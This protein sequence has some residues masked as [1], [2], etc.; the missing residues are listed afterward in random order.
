MI[1]EQPHRPCRTEE[2]RGK[3]RSYSAAVILSFVLCHF[4]N[5]SLALVSL[6][7]ANQAHGVL[8]DP[9]RSQAGTALMLTAA[10]THYGNA[11]WS[12]Y[13][14]RTLRLAKWEGWQLTLGLCIPFLLMIHVAGTR[15]A[16]VLYRVTPDYHYVLYRHWVTDPWL[17]ALQTA[18]LLTVWT[19]ACIGLR[20]AWRSA[21]WYPRWRPVLVAVMWVLPSLALAGYVSAGNQE[22]REARAEGYAEALLADANYS[23]AA[24]AGVERITYNGLA[25]H[26][27]LVVLPFAGRGVRRAIALRRGCPPQV[28]LPNGRSLPILTGATVLEALRDHG[29]PHASICGGRGR[30]TTCR[31]RIT[32]GLD[33][34]DPPSTL[35]AKALAR[36]G[37]SADTR[38]ACQIRP[39][40]DVAILPLLPPDV[41][42]APGVLPS[43]SDGREQLVTVVFVDLR[44]STTLGE[45]KLPYDMVFIVNRFCQE[46]N[47]ALKSTGG[48]YS[49]FTGD[50]LMALY[51]LEG[52]PADGG[53]HQALQGVA[54]MLARLENLNAELA[55]V[56]VQPLRM[57]VGMHWG[58]AIVGALGPPK[59]QIVTALGDTVNTAARLEGLTRDYDCKVVLSKA[60]AEAAGLRLDDLPVRSV[61]VKGRSQAVEFYALDDMPGVLASSDA[62]GSEG[63]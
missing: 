52:G 45:G 28:I 34:L 44:G 8:I 56:L 16:E 39:H 1:Q 19:H 36:S 12:I 43:V 27:G 55:S 13:V 40:H 33:Q 11:L 2:I 26:C 59:S 58:E 10:L 23:D 51:G 47:Q 14:R 41:G 17:V 62:R 54:V 31:V 38:L 3:A 30:C 21:A 7:L 25:V 29:V 60:A 37:V 35:E 32:S 18:A 46:M 5:H 48:H 42:A 53:A 20:L 15:M 22:R 50:G 9:W 4:I 63:L 49:Q 61:V 6:K 24:R 57:G